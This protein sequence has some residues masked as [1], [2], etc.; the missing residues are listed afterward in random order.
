MPGE[1]APQTQDCKTQ[2]AR[3]TKLDLTF[4]IQAFNNLA[5]CRLNKYTSVWPMRLT[6]RNPMRI[7]ECRFMIVD[8]RIELGNER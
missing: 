1:A 6:K 7:D 8:L 3:L 4:V 2:D 5:F